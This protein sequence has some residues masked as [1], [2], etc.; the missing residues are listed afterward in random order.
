[1]NKAASK[2]RCTL[3][4]ASEQFGVSTIFYA[5]FSNFKIDLRFIFDHFHHNVLHQKHGSVN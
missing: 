2:V 4:A 3:D 5:P 1:M